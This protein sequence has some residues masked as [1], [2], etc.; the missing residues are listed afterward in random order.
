MV[1]LIILCFLQEGDS[2]YA[3]STDTPKFTLHRL[4][5]STS[6]KASGLHLCIQASLQRSYLLGSS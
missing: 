1:F 6:Q 5:W 3:G 2:I 4:T